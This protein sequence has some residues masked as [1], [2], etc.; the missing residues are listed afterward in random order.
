M[1][2]DTVLR[3]L[4]GKI[5]DGQLHDTLKILECGNYFA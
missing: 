5:V 4:V 1:V 2:V 3:L